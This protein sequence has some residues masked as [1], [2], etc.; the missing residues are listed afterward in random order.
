MSTVS[1]KFFT[2]LQNSNDSFSLSDSENYIS[3][4]FFDCRFYNT[5]T[6]IVTFKGVSYNQYTDEFIVFGVTEKAGDLPDQFIDMNSEF[7]IKFLGKKYTDVKQLYLDYQNY[8][9]RKHIESLP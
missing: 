6:F 1:I 4:N 3:G 2:Q 5:G 9:V 7:F 8:L